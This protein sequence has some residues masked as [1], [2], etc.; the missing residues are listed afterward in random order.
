MKQKILSFLV[1][2]LIV[3]SFAP[4]FYELSK[5][6]TIAPNRSFELIHNYI[7]D[8]NFYLSRIRQ[9]YDGRWTVVERYT[10]EPHKGSLVQEFYL[11]L[12]KV[13]KNI[14]YPNLAVP[15]VYYIAVAVFSLLLLACTAWAATFL[16]PNMVWCILA[17]LLAVFACGWPIIVPIGTGWRFGG[18]MS[19]F[20]VMDIL[21]RITF[22]PHIVLGQ[23]M[24]L[25]L[26]IASNDAKTIGKIG[27]CIFLGILA[28]LLGMIFPPGLVF[29]GAGLV[30][31]M[32]IETLWNFKKYSHHQRWSWWRLVIMPR[33]II[34]L[35]SVPALLYYGW[36]LSFY[37]WRRLVDFEL[38]HPLQASLFEYIK[39]LGPVLPLGFI[40]LFVSL[41]KKERTLLG[42]ISWVVTWMVVFWI[43]SYIP[44]QSPLRFAEMA[45]H[46]PLAFLTI[47]LTIT[48]IHYVNIHHHIPYIGIAIFA[49]PLSY[50]VLG[51]GVMY[52]SWEWHKDFIDQKVQA[53][54]PEIS[55]N[56]YIVY[57]TVAFVESMI[58]LND[59][60]AP[61]SVI[62]SD[63][64]AGN[65]IPARTGRHVY[66]G[67]DNSINKEGKQIFV[68]RFFQG[69]MQ[70]KDAYYWMKREGI[71]FVFYGPQEQEHNRALDIML[72]YPFLRQVFTQ[73]GV[74][75][76]EVL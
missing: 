50:I 4:T 51:M 1:V 11:L 55:M 67:H 46:I 34:G 56:N 58:Y 40:G 36:I 43:F 59:S 6:E 7:T 15:L 10:N 2:V 63:L 26:L 23:A 72:Q 69:N 70:S 13:G 8:Y 60:T 62:L 22:L 14:P 44:Q 39:A 9:G 41:W 12:G 29:V 49:V 48:L 30:M 66:V 45:P 74:F 27:N 65:Y 64:A 61:S 28:F 24:V 47:Y 18:Y 21:Q 71:S 73:D 16:F 32:I 75:I 20:T 42:I 31:S 5:S 53:E 76:F 25:F 54:L 38:L 52:S 17:F 33:V 3:A 68:K 37:P 19:W 57:P 35:I